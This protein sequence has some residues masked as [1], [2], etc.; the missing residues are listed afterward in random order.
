M[1]NASPCP[2][3]LCFFQATNYSI[4]GFLFPILG[5]QKKMILIDGLVLQVFF[6]FFFTLLF[7]HFCHL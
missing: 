5:Y 7:A 2:D 3:V 1:K 6:L 4:F